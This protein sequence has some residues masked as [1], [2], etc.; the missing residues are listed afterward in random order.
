MFP[1]SAVL[2]FQVAAVEWLG[3]VVCCSVDRVVK[4]KP[5]LRSTTGLSDRRIQQQQ[6]KYTHTEQRFYTTVSAG[7]LCPAV[8]Q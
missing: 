4:G 7:I 5:N 8:G 2:F 3:A 1:V 6:Q